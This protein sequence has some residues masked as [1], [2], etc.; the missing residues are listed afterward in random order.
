MYVSKELN[1]PV[2]YRF[3]SLFVISISSSAY[4]VVSPLE[5]DK[6]SLLR[7][8]QLYASVRYDNIINS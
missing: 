7:L 4:V 2:S 6:K 3:I 1:L 5:M 8:T